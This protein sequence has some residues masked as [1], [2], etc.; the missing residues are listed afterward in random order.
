MVKRL[1]HYENQTPKDIFK[2]MNKENNGFISV[3]E[4][5]DVIEKLKLQG[6]QFKDIK[7]IEDLVKTISNKK[8]RKK[9]DIINT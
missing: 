3:K 8:K 2:M 4:I 7:A 9:S 6:E 5:K 1:E